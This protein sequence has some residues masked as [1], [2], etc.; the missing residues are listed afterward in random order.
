MRTSMLLDR[1]VVVQHC[2]TWHTLC[3]PHCVHVQTL[4]LPTVPQ[5]FMSG[6]TCSYKANILA[7]G[8]QQA[9]CSVA[10]HAMTQHA[11]VIQFHDVAG[12]V[13]G[14]LGCLGSLQQHAQVLIDGVGRQACNA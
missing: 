14:A 2:A 7:C 12:Q 13:C 11:P 5:G 4:H 10:G 8:S 3:T 6:K 1:R 9:A